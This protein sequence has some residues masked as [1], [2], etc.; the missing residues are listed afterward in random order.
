MPFSILS[1]ISQAALKDLGHQLDESQ[2][3]EVSE[4]TYLEDYIDLYYITSF[5]QGGRPK[6]S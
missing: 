2:S 4:E 3:L 5:L 6:I 1:L